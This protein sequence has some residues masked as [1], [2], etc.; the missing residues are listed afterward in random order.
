[1]I[2]KCLCMHRKVCIAI[3]LSLFLGFLSAKDY[4]GKGNSTNQTPFPALSN[5]TYED[6][7]N[8]G[9]PDL[10]RGKMPSG[11]PV[12]WIDDDDDM[13]TG[14][15]EGDLDNDCLLIDRNK[16]G[17]F[18]GYYDLSID[19]IDETDDGKPTLE[20]IVENNN[21]NI[22]GS[23]DW[24]AN[25]IWN[26]DLDNDQKFSYINWALTPV[27]TRG[28]ERDGNC[29]FYNDYMGETWFSKMSISSPR[30]SD[31]RYSWEVPFL[32]YD[33]DKDGQPE[34]AIR[35]V[36]TPIFRNSS[37]TS[38]FNGYSSD[39]DVL[40]NKKVTYAAVTYD[41]DNGSKVGNEFDFDLSLK[42]EGAGFDYSDQIHP[43]KNNK[44]VVEAD[45]YFFDSRWRKLTELIYPNHNDAFN[46]ISKRG[47]WSSC[48]FVFDEDND[49][50]RWERVEFYQPKDPFR[51]GRDNGGIDNNPQADAAGDRGEWDT[52]FSGKGKLYVGKFDGLIHLYGAEWGCWRMDQKASSFQGYGGLYDSPNP[53]QRL[54]TEPSQYATVKYTDTNNNGF[55]DKIEFDIDKDKVFEKTISLANLNIKDEYDLIKIDTLKYQNINELYTQVAE[56]NWKNALVAR[57]VAIQMGVDSIIY[58]EFMTPVT[59]RDKYYSG[60]WMNLRV[61]LDIRKL[62]ELKS[63]NVLVR[64]IDCAYFG[65]DWESLLVTKPND[66]VELNQPRI[67]IYPNPAR[68]YINIDLSSNSDSKFRVRIYNICGQIIKDFTCSNKIVKVKTDGLKPSNYFVLLESDNYKPFVTKMTIVN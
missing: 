58:K 54:Q 33:P 35:F 26:A 61:F 4:I 19:R 11:T 5:I 27:Q 55:V 40:Y 39:I 44:R 18:A 36:D 30:I 42:Y 16:D 67:N 64:K 1:M 23:F 14:D 48:W 56:N 43:I 37:N 46:L 60:Y 3:A 12:M 32:F 63:D 47:S 59:I 68:D 29:M 8:D 28:W 17:I 51:I 24:S 50:K 13:R 10:L 2:S 53:G 9:D 6:L 62:A 25:Y 7:D 57:R 45:K 34:M 49:C 22:R 15:L 38:L 41:M 20:V 65:R 52:D 21:P 31:L 66:I